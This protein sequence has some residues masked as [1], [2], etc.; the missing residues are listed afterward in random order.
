MSERG[1]FV[2][3]APWGIGAGPDKLQSIAEAEEVVAAWLDW[4]PD[5]PA[6]GEERE[7][8]LTLRQILRNSGPEP[9]EADLQSA[10]LAIKGFVRFARLREGRRRAAYASHRMMPSH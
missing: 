10:K 3:P 1:Q 4:T 7:R 8:I 9:S 6:Y 5:R 2:R